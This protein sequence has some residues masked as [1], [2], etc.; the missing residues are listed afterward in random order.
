[1]TTIIST[2]LVNGNIEVITRVPSGDPAIPDAVIKDIYSAKKGVISLDK[3][4]QGSI[5]PAHEVPETMVF[6]GDIA[7]TLTDLDTMKGIFNK[8]GVPFSIFDDGA[9]NQMIFNLFKGFNIIFN[10][11]GSLVGVIK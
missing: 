4:I 3:T 7:P 1:M 9:N 5:V 8:A 11:Q 2:E 6:D 10:A